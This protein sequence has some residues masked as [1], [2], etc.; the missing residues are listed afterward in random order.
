MAMKEFRI[1]TLQG[2]LGAASNLCTWHLDSQ[3][4][5]I[6]TN[7][8][9]WEFFFNLFTVT[10]AD[11]IKAHF[12][13]DARPMVISD[14]MGIAWICCAD[15]EEETLTGY[16][17]LGP[18]F[19]MEAS[20]DHI[21]N[22]CCKQKISGTLMQQ[23]ISLIAKLPIIHLNSTFRYCIMLYYGIY[24]KKIGANDVYVKIITTDE[25]ETPW[26]NTNRHDT[27]AAEQELF[28]RIRDNNVGNFTEIAAK[29]ASGNIG[30]M[31][32]GDPLRQTK[33]E[34]IVFATLCSRAAILGGVSPEGGYS[35]ADYYILRIEAARSCA[36]AQACTQEML[37]AFLRRVAQA[38]EHIRYSPTA[39]SC[40][41]YIQT[42]ISEKIS[43]DAMAKELGY[44]NYYLSSKFQKEVGMSINT[45]IGEQKIE[46]AKF[47]L[48]SSSLSIGDVSERLA[49]SSPSYF[50]LNFRKYTGMT[51]AE[52][53]QRK[54]RYTASAEF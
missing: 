10:C 11:E 16:Y 31:S 26:E 27:W 47:L 20:E 4:A 3:M 21:R 30:T 37:E 8:E 2:M 9:N 42:H 36:A 19:T 25:A 34:G 14:A 40:M 29:F 5:L 53:Q 41:E 52:W 12:A 1:K 17:L 44:N 32:N 49:F 51:P 7:C 13:L 39:A 43:L 35:L 46:Q 22:M 18:F 50:S 38:K 23:M 45:Y 28:A 48:D 54:D 33:N 15:K 6:D 24:E